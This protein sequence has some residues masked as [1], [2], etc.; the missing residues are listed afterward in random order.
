MLEYLFNKVD[1]EDTKEATSQVF[2]CEYCKI[3]KTTFFYGTL[4]LAA[5]AVLKNSDISR[6]TSV[7]EA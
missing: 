6:K 1:S 5:S 2:S 4:P 3:F 7:A